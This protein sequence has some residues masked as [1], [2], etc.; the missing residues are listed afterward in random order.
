MDFTLVR[1]LKDILP[2]FFF[3]FWGG[4]LGGGGTIAEYRSRRET[5]R[6]KVIVTYSPSRLLDWTSASSRLGE[7]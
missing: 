5:D 2:I 3:F 1:T 4:G 6:A 7:A